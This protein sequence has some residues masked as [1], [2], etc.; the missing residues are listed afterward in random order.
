MKNFKKNLKNNTLRFL[1]ASTALS[2][3]SLSAKAQTGPAVPCEEKETQNCMATKNYADK[4]YLYFMSKNYS[5]AIEAWKS[6]ADSGEAL[7]QNLLAQ[8][9][10]E[11]KYA[12]KNIP[13]AIALYKEAAEGGLGFAQAA[14]AKLYEEGTKVKKDWRLAFE[15]YKKAAENGI[16][17][18]QDTLANL[19]EQGRGTE[20][21]AIEAIRW[22]KL[23][24]SRGSIE[25]FYALGKLYQELDTTNP[26]N[27]QQSA[28]YYRLA[29]EKQYKPAQYEL[30]RLLF[31]GDEEG[32]NEKGIPRDKIEAYKW[33]R[34]SV[35]LGG[36]KPPQDLYIKIRQTLSPEE[37]ADGDARIA[38]WKKKQELEDLIRQE[39]EGQNK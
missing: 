6:G 12:P 10:M 27:N 20:R 17:E 2:L 28:L 4:G 35:D 34:L 26:Q 21:N 15:Y 31:E 5:K 36:A 39:Q 25:A 38:Q 33:S 9:Y 11:G 1:L 19:Y 13:R 3:A 14:L 8:I 30:A 37:T 16:P 32:F 18:A 29:A 7:S 23:S 22:Y 24:A